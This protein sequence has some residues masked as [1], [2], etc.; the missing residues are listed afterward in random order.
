MIL[1]S[2]TLRLLFLFALEAT[3]LTD[4]GIVLI[5][6]AVSAAV[7]IMDELVGCTPD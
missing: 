3:W 4:L 6:W 1:V 7:S 2:L 5:V